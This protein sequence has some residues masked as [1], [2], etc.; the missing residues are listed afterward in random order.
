MG[1]VLLEWLAL[2]L[3]LLLLIALGVLLWK[4]S[5]PLTGGELA[6][7]LAKETDSDGQKPDLTLGEIAFLLRETGRPA[8]ERLLAAVLTDWRARGLLSCEMAPKKRLS[9]YGEDLQP[10]MRIAPP[11]APPAGAEGALFALFAAACED[12]LQ[13]SEGYDWARQN[14]AAIEPCLLRFEAEGRARLRAEGALREETQKPL[15]GVQ[16]PERLIYT[17]RGLRRAQAMRVWENHLRASPET[18]LPHAILFG[19]AEPPQ[20]L[21]MHCGRLTQGLR[22][23]A[24]RPA[25]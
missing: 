7:R 8:S 2:N 17:P 20:P 21:A 10:T 5:R 9:G 18:D 24:A 11:D 14:A 23:A 16:R 1:I 13:S 3:A 4:R 6:K 22:S 25:G 19:Y 12:S 15:L